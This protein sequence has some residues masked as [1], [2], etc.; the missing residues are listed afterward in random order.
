MCRIV[1]VKY[2]ES[3]FNISALGA[4]HSLQLG[5]GESGQWRR[6][7]RGRRG[8]PPRH[9][10][11]TTI[12]TYIPLTL[13]YITKFYYIC[14]R[15]WIPNTYISTYHSRFIPKGVAVVSDIPPRQPSFTKITQVIVTA[16]N[17]VVA[18]YDI[19]GGKREVLFFYFVPDTIRDSYE[20]YI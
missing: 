16:I 15:R 17:P 13:I 7:W 12:Y 2:L 20:N 8:H 3:C 11:C 5:R 9:H 14:T 1:I 19:H 6:P 10:R 4:F 18:F